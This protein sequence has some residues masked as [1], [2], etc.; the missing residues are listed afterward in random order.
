M[1]DALQLDWEGALDAMVEQRALSVTHK[2]WRYWFTWNGDMRATACR[3]IE[4]DK[5]TR[6]DFQALYKERTGKR[7][8]V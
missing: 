4:S 1:T 2:G 5:Y 8:R 7:L 6:D 3:E